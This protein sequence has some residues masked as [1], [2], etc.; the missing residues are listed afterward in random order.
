MTLRK[1]RARAR[2][3]AAELEQRIRDA[4]GLPAA[5]FAKQSR[6]VKV[7]PNST[8]ATKLGRKTWMT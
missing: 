6:V 3:Q 4:G 2:K 5:A 8:A 7:H 1:S